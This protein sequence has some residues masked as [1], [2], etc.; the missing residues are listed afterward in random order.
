MVAGIVLIGEDCD[1]FQ[2]PFFFQ[3]GAVIP[4]LRKEDRLCVGT[5]SSLLHRK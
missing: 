1:G 3:T 2:Y 4:S 5:Q